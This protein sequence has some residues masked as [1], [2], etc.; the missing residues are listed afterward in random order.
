M[1]II[2]RRLCAVAASSRW[3]R[4]RFRALRSSVYLRASP[5]RRTRAFDE[6]Q[7]AFNRRSIAVRTAAISRGTSAFF[8]PRVSIGASQYTVTS[9]PGRINDEPFRITRYIPVTV[10]GT[11]GA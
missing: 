4:G 2:A 6:A 3:T 9:C 10:T 11:I 1:R 7:Y 8:V 5:H